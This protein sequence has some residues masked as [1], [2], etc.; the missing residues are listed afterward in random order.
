MLELITKVPTVFIEW[1]NSIS[2]SNEFVGGAIVAGGFGLIAYIGRSVPNGIYNAIKRRITLTLTVENAHEAYC[3]LLVELQKHAGD[4]GSRDFSVGY[5]D[6]RSHKF[7]NAFIAISGIGSHF[8]LYDKNLIWYTI[9]DL[10]SAGVSNQKQRITI[11][12][13][14]F[15]REVLDNFLR[16]LERPRPP[17][18]M[19]FF[20]YDVSKVYIGTMTTQTLDQVCLDNDTRACI[21]RILDTFK[22]N[23]KANRSLGIPDKLVIMLHGEPGN[24]KSKLIPAIAAYLE[25]DVNNINAA[26]LSSAGDFQ[27]ALVDTDQ[28]HILEDI[29]SVSAFTSTKQRQLLKDTEVGD[30]NK[31]DNDT[32]FTLSIQLSEFL[33]VLNGSVPLNGHVIILTTNYLDDLDPAIMRPGRTDY[34]IKLPRIKPETVNPWLEDRIKDFCHTDG[35]TKPI[36]G[37]D[38]GGLLQRSKGD[39][40]E[41]KRLIPIIE[42]KM[43]KEQ[44]FIYNDANNIDF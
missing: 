10:D 26:G 41:T 22:D 40:N 15:T 44:T 11:G 3:P 1:A 30:S 39:L 5:N 17:F 12:C 35:F 24:G 2:G 21:K 32:A 37:C 4:I 20:S 34:V 43:P 23:K 42:S 19:S 7:T 33:N 18:G 16:T 14:G 13:F 27:Q 25:K 31:S 8:F 29:H 28:V 9:S 38:I 6:K 36:R